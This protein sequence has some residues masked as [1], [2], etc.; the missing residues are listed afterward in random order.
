MNIT[1]IREQF[2][3]TKRM[4]FLNHAA[5]API[6]TCTLDAMTQMLR[7]VSE[8]GDTPSKGWDRKI[9]RT[10]ALAA[11]LIGASPKEIA[12]VKNTTEGILLVANGIDWREGDNVVLPEQEFP[13][14]VYPWL[15]LKRLGVEARFVP[16][17]DGRVPFEETEARVDERTRCIAI[18]FVQF[19]SGFRADLKRLGELCERRGI[20]LCVD[21][22]QGLGAL[23]LDVKDCKIHFLSADGHKWLL[24]PEGAG[25]FYCDGSVLERLRLPNKGWMGV[26][27]P[28]DYLNYDETPAPSARRFE[29]GS[30]NTAGIIGLGATLEFLLD[31]GIEEIEERVIAITDM[32]C[33]GL[34]E[35][36][37]S[38]Y[39]SRRPGETSGI[40]C[41]SHAAHDSVELER[42]FR[43]NSIITC[44]RSG[45]VRVSPHFYNSEE[46]I[47]KLVGLVK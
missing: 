16:V 41:F 21:A 6:P 45:R 37:C 1:E 44:V 11:E 7:E 12:F 40:V 24:S 20:L 32:L 2:P 33:D 30:Y 27:N 8:G 23:Q 34:R 9:E 3:I 29:C 36:G 42:T 43:Q 17:T 25:I 46:E 14:N 19:A 18:S 35:R 22:I 5:V 28:G 13:A 47:E 39:S 4:A 26:V 31:V 15:N 10:R 38:I